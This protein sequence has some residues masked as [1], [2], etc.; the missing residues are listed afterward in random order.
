MIVRPPQ[1]CETEGVSLSLSPRLQSSGAI[2]ADCS[3][4]LLGSNDP[5]TLASCI[6]R[7]GTTGQNAEVAKKIQVT[8]KKFSASK[9]LST[10]Q[11]GNH[12]QAKKRALKGKPKRWLVP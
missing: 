12:E 1:P 8:L 3:L 6:L 10:Q 9:K 5:P 7:A 2:I 11:E 4:E